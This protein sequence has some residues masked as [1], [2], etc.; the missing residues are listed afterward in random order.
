[1][2]DLQVC[3]ADFA[4]C[5]AQA[6]KRQRR[7]HYKMKLMQGLHGDRRTISSLS[8]V[9]MRR[10]PRQVSSSTLAAKHPTCCVQSVTHFDG[11]ASRCILSSTGCKQKLL[12][13]NNIHDLVHHEFLDFDRGGEIDVFQSF[14]HCDKA[15]LLQFSSGC[16]QGW[17]KSMTNCAQATDTQT[18]RSHSLPATASSHARTR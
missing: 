13:S 4:V 3:S 18:S 14:N 9:E 12:K 7:A 16:P 5:P 17:A 10:A 8:A 15:R 11:V 1:M 6:S 2:A